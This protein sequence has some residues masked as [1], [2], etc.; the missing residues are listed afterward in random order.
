[1]LAPLSVHIDTFVNRIVLVPI[2]LHEA[3][4]LAT[5]PSQIEFQW[6]FCIEFSI[7]S[8]LNTQQLEKYLFE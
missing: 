5:L 8:N 1:M 4:L 6:I 7:V 2:V 3:A